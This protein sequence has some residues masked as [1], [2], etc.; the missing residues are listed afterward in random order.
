LTPVCQ[1]RLLPL[2]ADYLNDQQ[3]PADHVI[4]T[5]YYTC[6]WQCSSCDLIERHTSDPQF[7]PIALTCP[8]VSARLRSM[9]QELFLT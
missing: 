4:S 7:Q 1:T 2:E 8:S 5:C 9:L 3:F 6:R